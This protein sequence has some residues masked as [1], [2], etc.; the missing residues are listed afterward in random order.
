VKGK[1]ESLDQKG[2]NS[3]IQRIAE[4]RRF[5]FVSP[6]QFGTVAYDV[7][8]CYVHNFQRKDLWDRH[9]AGM[10]RQVWRTGLAHGW[11]AGGGLAALVRTGHPVLTHGTRPKLARQR[12][13]RQNCGEG[14]DQQRSYSQLHPFSWTSLEGF[15]RNILSHYLQTQCLSGVENV[16]AAMPDS[17]RN[18]GMQVLTCSEFVIRVGRG[19][20][21]E[22]IK[23]SA[24]PSAFGLGYAK[25]IGMRF[26]FTVHF[27]CEHRPRMGLSD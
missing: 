15:G 25:S 26:V 13:R 20:S 16:P 19:V 9:V 10:G 18:P 8:G 2:V 14:D 4:S 22:R 27:R 24:V 21:S 11:R 7:K 17:E 1:K 6:N 3:E 23:T 5:T 12:A